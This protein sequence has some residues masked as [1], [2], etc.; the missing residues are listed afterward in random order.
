[1]LCFCKGWS[2]VSP[3]PGTVRAFVY[4]EVG[5]NHPSPCMFVNVR[6]NVAGKGR[7][8]VVLWAFLWEAELHLVH[9]RVGDG[10]VCAGVN[11]SGFS[12]QL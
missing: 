2:K 3:G 8:V 1:M 12:V 7:A 10:V 5:R 6:D 4:V 9:L 11:Q